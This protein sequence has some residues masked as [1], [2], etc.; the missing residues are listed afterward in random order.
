MKLSIDEV[1]LHEPVIWFTRGWFEVRQPVACV[2]TFLRIGEPHIGASEEP[3][4]WLTL[5]LL[6]VAFFSDYCFSFNCKRLSKT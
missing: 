1:N 6:S 3:R 2:K 4:N 5:L